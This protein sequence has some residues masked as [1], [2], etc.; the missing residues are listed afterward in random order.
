MRSVA[1]AIA[2]PMAAQKSGDPRG[3]DYGPRCPKAEG[4]REFFVVAQSQRLMESAFSLTREDV[5]TAD[6]RREVRDLS[7]MP[8]MALNASLP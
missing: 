4:G 1:F 6:S 7:T 2:W 3:G 8:T 5:N